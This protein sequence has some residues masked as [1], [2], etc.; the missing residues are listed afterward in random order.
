MELQCVLCGQII[1]VLM[2]II[3]SKRKMHFKVIYEGLS[4]FYFF[5]WL[6]G[7]MLFLWDFCLEIARPPDSYILRIYGN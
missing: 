4:I 2:E 7:K 5:M 6:F 3:V 1:F